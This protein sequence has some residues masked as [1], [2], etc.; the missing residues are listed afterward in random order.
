MRDKS[1]TYVSLLVFRRAEQASR[2]PDCR[3]IIPRDAMDAARVLRQY[4]ADH[5]R[6]DKKWE[7]IW[8]RV[9]SRST[10]L[11]LEMPNFQ[12]LGDLL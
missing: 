7:E 10:E 12:E 4:Y 6:T 1:L 9:I 2:R 11:D 3:G 8:Q 5:L